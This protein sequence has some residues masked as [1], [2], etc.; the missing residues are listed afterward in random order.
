MTGNGLYVPPIKI[1]KNGDDWGMV[2]L[3]QPVLPTLFNVIRC[4]SIFF[5]GIGT[6]PRV[7]HPSCGNGHNA[8]RW[9]ISD[10]VTYGSQTVNV[11][12]VSGDVFFNS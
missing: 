7:V 1:Y 10:R 2:R 5:L 8:S 9:S 3:W 6:A 12:V 11:W 4:D